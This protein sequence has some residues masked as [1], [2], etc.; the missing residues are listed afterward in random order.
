MFVVVLQII[1]IK[2][3]LK[4]NKMRLEIVFTRFKVVSYVIP[5]SGMQSIALNPSLTIF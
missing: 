4:T 3:H 2:C 5:N 1:F